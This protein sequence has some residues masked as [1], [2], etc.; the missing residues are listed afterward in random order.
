[1]ARPF[2]P[3]QAPALKHRTMLFAVEGSLYLRCQDCDWRIR[4]RQGL[5]PEEAVTASRD[6]R[7]DVK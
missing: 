4:L 6:H 3:K 7:K 2:E 1:M 5:S